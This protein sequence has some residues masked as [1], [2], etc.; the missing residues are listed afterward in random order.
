M[1]RPPPR[2]SE[3]EA[4]GRQGG[5]GQKRVGRGWAGRRGP[6]Q[7]QAGTRSSEWKGNGRKRGGTERHAGECEREAAE[8]GEQSL[9]RA[10]GTDA[11]Y[12][13]PRLRHA[14]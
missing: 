1:K 8:G 12:A 3:A 11:P 7:R 10:G 6:R 4:G 2:H 13:R 5:G 9:T 14:R